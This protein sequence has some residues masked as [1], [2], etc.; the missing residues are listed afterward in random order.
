VPSA[1]LPTI[2][3]HLQPVKTD[4]A[5][6]HMKFIPTHC[7]CMVINYEKTEIIHQHPDILALKKTIDQAR[8]IK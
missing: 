2:S 1:F 3:L 8:N 6:Y 4:Y 7:S 5:K